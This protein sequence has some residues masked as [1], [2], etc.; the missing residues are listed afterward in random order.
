[1]RDSFDDTGKPVLPDTQSPND[2]RALTAQDVMELIN[3]TRQQGFALRDLVQND[4]DHSFKSVDLFTRSADDIPNHEQ[5]TQTADTSE[6]QDL[7]D[8]VADLK[9]EAQDAAHKD[10]DEALSELATAFDEAERDTSPHTEPDE[11]PDQASF[12]AGHEAGFSQGFAQ[13]HQAG[14]EKGKSEAQAQSRDVIAAELEA[15]KFAQL[16]D[17]IARL[18]AVASQL[19]GVFEQDINNFSEQLT[20]TVYQLVNE[21]V[22][23][24]IDAHPRDFIDKIEG[25]AERITSTVSDCSIRVAPA[26][27]QVI[28]DQAHRHE[29]V[30]AAKFSAD[31]TLS[32]GD[33][34]IRAGNIQMADV[35]KDAL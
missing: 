21:R 33:V 1:M 24:E 35:L 14:E 32:R 13:G 25:L 16:R 29:F 7:A 10:T 22:G 28:Q 27:L 4:T 12:D 20:Q 6:I 23:R 9:T 5:D 18:D 15:E 34:L 31:D 26:D 2:E 17:T 19:T 30:S 8:L 3:K 11:Q